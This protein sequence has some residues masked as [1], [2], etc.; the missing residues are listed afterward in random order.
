MYVH[1]SAE[2]T[3]EN[4]S[5]VLIIEWSTLTLKKSMFD[6][7]Q[8]ALMNIYHEIT[9][10]FIILHS[11]TWYAMVYLFQNTMVFTM[12]YNGIFS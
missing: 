8:P 11:I 5:H 9:W 1:L 4:I 7:T 10:H 6:S 2:K 12:E 3:T